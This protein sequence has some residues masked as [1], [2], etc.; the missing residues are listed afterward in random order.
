MPQKMGYAEGEL[1]RVDEKK[2][3][4]PTSDQVD[5]ILEFLKSKAKAG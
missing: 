5:K 3:R 4:E 1:N 2:A